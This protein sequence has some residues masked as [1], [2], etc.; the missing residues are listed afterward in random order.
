MERAGDHFG[1]IGPHGSRFDEAVLLANGSKPMGFV[2]KNMFDAQTPAQKLLDDAVQDGRLVRRTIDLGDTADPSRAQAVYYTPDVKDTAQALV[3]AYD[4]FYSE[5]GPVE[6]T[7]REIAMLEGSMVKPK[8]VSNTLVERVK[9]EFARMAWQISPKVGQ[10]TAKLLYRPRPQ[11]EVAA[12]DLLS[13]GRR[14][15]VLPVSLIRPVDREQLDAMVQ[16]GTLVRQDFYPVDKHKVDLYAR[17]D[18]A[19]MLP[20]L[21]AQ[22]RAHS[23]TPMAVF[24]IVHAALLKAGVPPLADML[25]Y[26]ARDIAYFERRAYRA[27]WQRRILGKFQESFRQ[28]RKDKM[29]RQGFGYKP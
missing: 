11:Y 26:E 9:Y 28:A 15:G 13:G 29:M 23:G 6:D 10:R 18:L 17:Q 3:T 7:L 16:A 14:L 20:D 5:D 12:E 21:E 24:G 1:V 19:H 2:L 8:A 22:V 25:G 4:R 27:P